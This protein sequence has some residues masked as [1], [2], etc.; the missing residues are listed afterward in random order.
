MKRVAELKTKIATLTD[1]ISRA[2]KVS[3]MLPGKE[4]KLEE[5]TAELAKANK[6]D[7]K[8]TTKNHDKEIEYYFS[9]LISART[10][11]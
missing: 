1:L 10:S 4:K 3:E 5:L 2:K 11:V 9:C 6:N 7:K 8:L